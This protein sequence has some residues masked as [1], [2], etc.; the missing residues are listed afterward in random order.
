MKNKRNRDQENNHQYQSHCFNICLMK[1]MT[2]DEQYSWS[3][4]WKER[5]LCPLKGLLFHTCLF[6]QLM[7]PLDFSSQSYDEGMYLM[8]ITSFK[9]LRWTAFK[10]KRNH[11]SKND[12]QE[13]EKNRVIHEVLFS[14]SNKETLLQPNSWIERTAEETNDRRRWQCVLYREC[15]ETRRK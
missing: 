2:D 12:P 14:T 3:S 6:T 8:I 9:S 10:W 15:E 13:K 11:V 7:I 4:E 1:T 5:L